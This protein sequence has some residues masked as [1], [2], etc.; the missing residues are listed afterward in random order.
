MRPIERIDIFLK[1]LGDKWKEAPDLRFGQ[2]LYNQ[3]ILTNDTNPLNF[4]IEEDEVLEMMSIDPVRYSL[5]GTRGKD[6]K[7]PLQYKLLIDC[8]TDHLE[9]ILKTQS[10]ISNGTRIL[11]MRILDSRKVKTLFTKKEVEGFKNV[12]KEVKTKKQYKRKSK[13]STKKSKK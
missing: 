1:C 11:I 5:W 12:K 3:G 7:Q 2:F 6:G 13:V 10:Q 8:D 9:A 4:F